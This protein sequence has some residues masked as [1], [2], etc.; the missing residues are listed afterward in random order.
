MR[1]II[2]SILIFLMCFTTSYVFAD[3]ETDENNTEDNNTTNTTNEAPKDLYT[4]RNDLKNQLEEQ[5][6]NLNNVQTDLS[7]NLQ[8]IGKLDEKIESAENDLAEQEAKITELKKSIEEVKSNLKIVN[9]KYDKQ[10]EL[11]EQRMVSVYEDG[12]T[13]Y[14]DVLLKSKD[15]SDFISSYYVISQLAEIDNNLVD[16]LYEKKNSI[17]LYNQKLENERKELAI[18]IENQTRTSR[19]L[20]NTK[21]LR[22]S[23]VSKLSDEEKGI[24]DKIDEINQQYAIINKQILSMNENIDSE[25]IGGELAWPVPGYTRINSPYGMRVHPITQQYKLHTGVD[26]GAPLGA[27]FVAANDGVVEKAEYNTAYGNMVVINH[28]GGISTLYAHGSEIMVEAGQE[29]KRG[30]IV[31][32]V[33]STGYSTGPHAHFEIRIKGVPTNPMPYIT[34]GLVPGTEN[35]N[36]S[37][38]N[39]VGNNTT[40]NTDANNNTN[41]VITNKIED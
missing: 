5:N 12:D 6:S 1:K 4:Q 14:L 13:T 3:N 36:N 40:N 35:S 20:Q 19:T 24:Q 2:V 33:G 38:S 37:D 17:D 23:F 25:Y 29:V 8:Q 41:V 31:L 10:K 30:D 39:T 18:I 34:N 26:I 9:E 22:E 32:K 27:N 28:G 15:L 21:V 7:D 11:F 16:E